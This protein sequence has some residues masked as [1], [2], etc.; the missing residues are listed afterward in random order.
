MS[1]YQCKI[2]ALKKFTNLDPPNE[3]TYKPDSVNINFY[4]GWAKK[5]KLIE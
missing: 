2:I 1:V 3:V 5:N 4:V